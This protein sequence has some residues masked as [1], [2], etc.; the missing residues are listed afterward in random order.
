MRPWS[1]PLAGK[2][3]TRT[4][5]S[6]LLAG[7][8]RG[9]PHERPLWI[10]L[11]PGYEGESR[12]YPTIYMLQGWTGQIDMWR[13]RSALRM[14]PIELFDE[15]FASGGAPA[16]LVFVDAWTSWGGSQFLDSPGLGP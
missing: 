14:N 12:R 16:I 8:R 15:M 3:E 2:L 4:I 5:Q 1:K 9:D 11:P 10:Y 13:N 7:N 6:K